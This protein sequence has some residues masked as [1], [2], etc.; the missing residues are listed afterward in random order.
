[1]PSI[2]IC[3]Q[4]ACAALS[5]A[6]RS[7]GTPECIIGKKHQQQ[8]QSLK[9]SRSASPEPAGD[10]SPFSDDFRPYIGTPPPTRAGPPPS[11]P[12][13]THPKVPVAPE[14]PGPQSL[15]PCLICGRTFL[16][17]SLAKHIKICEKMAAKKRKTFDS[18]RQRREGTDLE[19]YLPKNFGLPENSPFLEKSPPPTAKP[20]PKPKPHSVRNAIT[21]PTAELQKCPHC[22]RNFGVRA[23]ERH[24][25]WCADKAKILPAAPV[26]PPQHI[27]DAKQRLDARTKYKAPLARGRR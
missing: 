7:S 21:K 3:M 8:Q 6:T 25:E 27:A 12:V 13:P 14:P 4:C 24:V 11:P 9:S 20:T 18:S 22:K 2:E 23:F 1:M 16:P 17:P 26:Q 10:A 15:K 5:S 19:Q